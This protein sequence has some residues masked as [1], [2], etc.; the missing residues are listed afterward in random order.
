MRPVSSA[1]DITPD[2]R[3]AI[4]VGFYRAHR[5]QGGLSSVAVRRDRERDLWFL[6]VGTTGPVDVP[7]VYRGLEVRIKHVAG[8][9]NAVARLDQLLQP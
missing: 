1:V 5:A 4:R 8:G 2:E 9:V 7:S 6:D 3:E